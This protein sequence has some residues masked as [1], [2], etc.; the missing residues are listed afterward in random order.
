MSVARPHNSAYSNGQK[1]KVSSFFTS[2]LIW[3]GVATVA[4]YEA[5]PFVPYQ[6]PLFERYFCSHP[7]EYATATLFFVGLAILVSKAIRLA[8]ERSALALPLLKFQNVDKSSAT[9]AAAQ[10]ETQ[11]DKL[12]NRWKQTAVVRRL[13]DV[14]HHVRSGATGDQLEG[15]LKYLADLANERLHDSYAPVRTITWAIPIVGFLGTVIGITIAIANVTPDQLDQSLNEVTG[16]LAVAF[17]T[18][19]L[20]L[21]LSLVMV[22]GAF[23]VERSEQ[24]ILTEVEDFGI[25]HVW[26]LFSN[27]GQRSGSWTDIQAETAEVLLEKTDNL[28]HQQVELWR[29]SLDEM[30]GR[31]NETIANQQSAIDES[32]QIGVSSTLESHQQQLDSV[33]QIFVE[34][35]QSGAAELGHQFTQAVQLQKETQKEFVEQS[36]QLWQQVSDQSKLEFEEQQ[37]HTD[38]VMHSIASLLST[39]RNQIDAYSQ[40]AELQWAELREQR[41]ML[42]QIMTDEQQLVRLQSRLSDNLETVR[43]AETLDETLHSLSA[44]VHLLTNRV[45]SKAA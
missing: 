16:G 2:P 12:S 6:R 29:D 36:L 38:H 24:Q 33:K 11:L 19:A 22:F 21:G 44:A 13:H 34:A 39:S 41:E 8:K 17:D 25:R 23:L 32:L 20:A 40:Q 28:V 31:W 30:R 1:S 15:H 37:K 45:K 26:G 4:F 10:L 9:D 3:G 27:K 7:L 42:L 14:V 5:I 18:T 43:S 35:F